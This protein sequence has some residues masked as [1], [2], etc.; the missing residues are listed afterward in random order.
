MKIININECFEKYKYEYFFLESTNSTMDDIKKKLKKKSK[1]YI[2]RANQQ[3][4][5]R[6]RRG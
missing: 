1:N 4:K 5:G 3:K 2:V 6:G